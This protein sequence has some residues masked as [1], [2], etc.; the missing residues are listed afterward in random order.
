MAVRRDMFL[1]DLKRFA[2]VALDTPIL[3]YHLE[4]LSPY[5]QLT[6]AAFTAIAE[7]SPMAILSTITITELLVQP[8]AEGPRHRVEA[9]E[10]FLLTL[11]NTALIP[12]DYPIAKEAARLRARYGIRAPDALLTAT[13]LNQQ[14]QALLTN[15]TRLRRLKAEG[16]AVLLLDSYV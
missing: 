15:D 6:E 10:R 12:P 3:I 13:A 16:I 11:P 8:F 2:K 14:A 7:G 4:D 5:S 1:A 9:C